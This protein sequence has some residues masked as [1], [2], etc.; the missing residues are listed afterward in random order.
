MSTPRYNRFTYLAIGE[1]P[2]SL[3]AFDAF[4][5]DVNKTKVPDYAD[6]YDALGYSW[7]KGRLYAMSRK[8]SNTLVV[9]DPV[10]GT[11]TTQQV[12][13]LS[14]NHWVLGA[15]TPDG[16]KLVISGD[17]HASGAVLDLTADPVTALA[18]KPP[19]YGGWYDWAYHPVDERLYAVDGDTG[20][21]MYADPTKD[22]QKV[23]LKTEAFPKAKGPGRASY[24][25]V[26][27]EENGWFY[28]FD[29]AGNVYKLDLSSSTKADPIPPSAIGTAVTVGRGPI[30]VNDLNVRDAGGDVKKMVNPP[31]YEALVVN[32]VLRSPNPWEEQLNGKPMLV[33]SFRVNITAK[34]KHTGEDVDVRKW[35]IFFDD[36]PGS[37]PKTTAATVTKNKEQ[38]LWVLDTPGENHLITKG[39]TLP[40]DLLLYVPKETPLPKPYAL[41]NLGARRLA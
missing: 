1:G 40:V 39:Q 11:L 14:A 17:G 15:I 9:I 18:Q 2:T 25:A 4:T 10:A 29:N 34:L 5:G 7:P 30:N 37:E 31:S 32:Q 19:G 27:F 24:S 20:A 6:G 13:Q 28:A 21:L 22:P 38:G 12:S 3:Y 26:F 8:S 41:G 16:D 23:V 36:V 35:R 33:Y